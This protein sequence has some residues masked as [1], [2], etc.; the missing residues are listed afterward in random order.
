MSSFGK[1]LAGFAGSAAP[2][3]S[4]VRWIPPTAPHRP[5]ARSVPA[6]PEGWALLQDPRCSIT[7]KDWPRIPVALRAA[8]RPGFETSKSGKPVMRAVIAGFGIEII[9]GLT[10]GRPAVWYVKNG[11][12][13]NVDISF[14]S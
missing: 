7:Y 4:S 13:S 12:I 14:Y 6:M 11:D 3:A 1:F 8:L 5:A 9:I 2:Q 10:Q